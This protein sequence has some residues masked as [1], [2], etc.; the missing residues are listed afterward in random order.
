LEGNAPAPIEWLY[1]L[2]GALLALRYGWL[3]DDAFVYFRY[4][5][6]LLFLDLGLVY[7]QGEYVEGYTGPLWV[8]LLTPLR[9]LGLDYWLLVRVIACAGFAL[10][11]FLLV[12]VNRELSPRGPIL[13]LP[14]AFLSLNYGVLCY[15]TSGTESPL[16][17]V[18]AACYALFVL[19]PGSIPLQISLALSP[20]ARP[21]LVIPLGLALLWAWR[22]EGKIPWWA[23][24]MSAVFNGGW[25]LFRIV[26]YADLLPNTFYL[27]DAVD[28]AQGWAYVWNS[29]APYQLFYLLAAGWVAVL[30]L[31]RGPQAPDSR[32][33]IEQRLMLLA[34]ALPVLL[35]VIKIGGG[36][37]HLRYLVFPFCLSLCSLAGLPEHLAHRFGLVRRRWIAPTA[38]ALVAAGSFAL[39]PPQLSGHPFFAEREHTTVDKINDAY[40]HRVGIRYEDWSSR[41]DIEQMERF[42]DEHVEFRY[43]GV[44]DTWICWQSYAQFETRVI[45]SLGLTD[46]ILARTEMRADRP[47]HKFG[48]YPLAR[49]LRRI[50]KRADRIGRGMYRRAVAEGDAPD[51]IARNLDSLEI[52]ER[53]IYNVRD[54][55][56][57]LSL[58][59]TFPDRIRP[60]AP[61]DA[62][63]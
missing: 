55:R 18:F 15:F 43:R 23:I 42:R 33:G 44:V 53:K 8:L 59:F 51:W 52:I 5:D 24:G 37:R 29:A 61:A 41:A 3:L 12:Q 14:L 25:L 45:N 50:Q 20:L 47:A 57:N 16:V 13:N 10:F 28:I 31:R 17:L 36:P 30:V 56:E 9:F 27:K 11:W 34:L 39:F 6:N 19:R 49:D 63:E 46:A 40:L 32:L 22:R 1:L 48:L 60:G 62:R 38:G 35:Y 2:L 58:A 7:N 54:F 21:E 26:Y 4:I